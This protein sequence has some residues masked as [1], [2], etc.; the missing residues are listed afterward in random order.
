MKKQILKIAGVKSEKEFYK[1]FPT[2]EAF[3]AKHGKELKKAQIGTYMTSEAPSTMYQPADVRGMY[4]ELDYQLTGM[5]SAD[6]AKMEAIQQAA[7]Q[8]AQS[9]GDDSGS[10]G[11]M[12][13]SQMAQFAEMAVGKKGKKITKSQVG[14]EIP[15]LGPTGPQL[16]PSAQNLQQQQFNWGTDYNVPAMPSPKKKPNLAKGIPVIGQVI[17]GIQNIKAQREAYRAAKQQTALTDVM[18]QAAASRPVQE[19]RRQYVRPEDMAFQPEQMFPSY[20][21]GTNVLAEFGASVGGGEIMNTYA[22][23]TLYDNLGYEPLNDSERYKQF[24]HGGKLHKAAGGGAFMDALGGSQGQQLANIIGGG[25]TG[26]WSEVLGGIGSAIPVPGVPFATRLIGSAVDKLQQDKI[27]N[28]QDLSRQN[29]NRIIGQSFGVGVQQQFGANMQD[30]GT[31]S[32]YKWVSHTWQPQKIV[33]F[34]GHNLKDLLKPP[35]DADMLRAGGHLKAYTPPSER[36]MSTERPVMQM[37]GELETHWGGYAEPMSY[38]PYLP[39]GGETIMF[40]G[41]SHDESDG[42]GNTG[43]GITYGENPVEVERGEPAVKLQ[44]GTSGDS[45]LVVFGNLKIPKSYIPMLG[46][47]AKGKKFK[48]YVADLSKKE[49]KQNKKLDKATQMLED[50]EVSTPIDKMTLNSLQ[51]TML[52]ANQKLKELADKKMT[53]ASLQNAINDTAEEMGLVAD[54]LARGKVKMDKKAI[55]QNAQFGGLFG[56][57]LS[58]V[59]RLSRTAR[60]VAPAMKMMLPS[61]A[62]GPL[63]IPIS[64]P[65]LPKATAQ[66]MQQAAPVAATVPFS[67]TAAP[68]DVPDT[69][70]EV[71]T[72]A[73]VPLSTRAAAAPV[74]NTI[75][76]DVADASDYPIAT[77]EEAK[78]RQIM[79]LYD[80]AKAANAQNPGKKNPYILELQKRYHAYFPDIAKKIILDAGTV[81]ARA[82]A[83]GINSLGDLKKLSTD[84]ILD[85]NLDMFFGPRTEQYIAALPKKTPTSIASGELN[86]EKKT[87]ATTTDD[88]TTVRPS[89][90]PITPYKRNPLLDI[91]GQVLPYVRPTDTEELDPRQLIGEMYAL[92]NNQLEPVQAQT[93]QP[94]LSTPY[95]ISLQDILNENEASFR[96]QQRMLG[97]NPAAQSMLNAQKYA[98]NQKVLGEQFRANQ[99]MKDAVYRENRNL[100]NEFGLKNLEILDRQYVRQETAKSKTKAITQSAL[101]SIGDKF[102]RN[103]L[104]NRKLATA[105]NLYNFRYDPRFRT[106]N[107][108]APFQPQI[109][110]VYVG[111]DGK[112]YQ[113]MAPGTTATPPI[114]SQ[115]KVPAAAPSAPA[116]QAPA[117]ITEQELDDQMFTAEEIEEQYKRGGRKGISVSKKKSLN[118]SVVKAFKNL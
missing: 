1:K 80:K 68:I 33:S 9:G 109:P 85:T 25:T 26:G 8:L 95:D 2:E 18:G 52:G 116:V 49:N 101:S 108:N 77:T 40:R 64:V 41:Q 44:D 105:E 6:R 81:T 22:P 7:A 107:M 97:Y 31:T 54:D 58:P 73:V 86:V 112:Q 51:Y 87:T 23:G 110:T 29:V 4:D 113:V 53:A 89:V 62:S 88:K 28:Q 96:S 16:T 78:V 5:T 83:K 43:I 46:E 37:G 98:A 94:Q 118:S 50:F 79:E 12:D 57:I 13:M 27:E 72:P 70:E 90:I 35:H 59:L 111:P 48:T 24:Y 100:L 84:E 75:A 10:G 19:P 82:K 66:Q 102:M 69:E 32:P 56:P 36:A 61:G 21:V 38:N 76:A 14:N 63:G 67:S 42:R 115:G 104:E 34:G 117:P 17:G 39:D 71:I 99:A 93:I 47:E 45:N 55:K 91:I 114:V 103:Q 74:V 3:M 15:G 60:Q 65:S 106:I 20:G 11:G 30:G 92:A